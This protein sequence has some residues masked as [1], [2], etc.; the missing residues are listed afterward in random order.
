MRPWLILFA[1]LPLACAASQSS[2]A[3][4]P[5]AP[6][7]GENA[8]ATPSAASA[9]TETPSSSRIKP[10]SPYQGEAAGKNDQYSGQNVNRW[11]DHNEAK[12]RSG[13]RID[14]AACI[15]TKMQ[16]AAWCQGTSTMIICEG[17]I[18]YEVDCTKVAPSGV[19]ALNPTGGN[20][21]DC[22]TP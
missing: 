6:S 22:Y 16:H 19:C 5:T 11:L 13:E 4:T 10:G 7:S 18:F 8:A 1:F 9:A 14:G 3:T 12:Q 17:N 2:V 20:T 15:G 21:I